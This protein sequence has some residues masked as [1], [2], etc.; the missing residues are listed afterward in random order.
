MEDRAAIFAV[1]GETGEVE[2]EVA[3]PGGEGQRADQ[4]G[5]VAAG[6]GDRSLASDIGTAAVAGG[7]SVE[8]VLVAGGTDFHRVI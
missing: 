2:H 3:V 7:A 1:E 5:G 8:G 6:E 4:S